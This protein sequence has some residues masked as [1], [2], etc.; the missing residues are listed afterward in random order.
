M[1]LP[2][3]KLATLQRIIRSG[4]ARGVWSV[5]STA[6]RSRYEAATRARRVLAA[7]VRYGPPR[8]VLA[9]HGGIGDDVVLTVLLRELR[10]RGFG[11]VWVMSRYPDLYE[12]NDD[13]AAVLPWNR[14][15]YAT[16]EQLG[17]PAIEPRYARYDRENDHMRLLAPERHM[18][19][20]MCQQAG[21]VGPI[22]RRP[23]VILRDEE[24]A[25][26][27]RAPRQVVI[28]SSGL[29]AGTPML[30]KQWMVERFQEVVSAAGS[31][32]DFVQL[33]S[34]SD[35][36]LE[37]VLDLRGQTS[38]RETAAILS[39]SFAFIG[40]TGFL[41]HLARA[42]ECRSVIVYGGRER[43]DQS[44]YACNENLYSAV[45]CAPCWRRNRCDYDRRCLT[46]IGAGDVVAA[47]GRIA[48][49]HGTPLEEDTDVVAAERLDPPL[50]GRSAPTLTITTNTG[51]LR[52]IEAKILADRTG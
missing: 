3:R 37:G 44:G 47:L 4:G 52:R 16:L 32:F 45:P 51:K 40:N 24:R 26:G 43:P 36:P 18:I 42:V 30:N 10:R 8:M 23:H 39:Q 38:R 27:R 33:G 12:H 1:F 50:P 11:P 19:T 20:T 46:S 5:V 13:V 15:Y 14:S 35:P 17:V 48:V 9:Y 31:E 21:I 49:R 22:V 41:M 7:R 2:A 29:D 34:R 25:A 28:Q 6:A